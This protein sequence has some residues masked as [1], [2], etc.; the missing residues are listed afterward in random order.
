[1]VMFSD[2][3]NVLYTSVGFSG[4]VTPIQYSSVVQGAGVI[5]TALPPKVHFYG[6]DPSGRLWVLHQ[7]GWDANG[8]PVWAR[9]LPLDRYVARVASPQS[10]LQAATLF[11]AGHDQTLHVLSQDRTSKLWKRSL[12]QRPGQQAVPVDPVPDAADGDRPQRQSRPRGGGHHRRRRGGSDPSRRQNLFRGSRRADRDDQDQRG[13]G[14]DPQ[15]RRDQPGLTQL[16]GYRPG[17]GGGPDRPPRPGLPQLSGTS[18]INTGSAVIRPMSQATLQKATVA[19]QPLSPK[20]G[21]SQAG[22]AANIKNAMESVPGEL[23]GDP[24]RPPRR[25]S[26]MPAIP[27]TPIPVL[28]H[29]GGPPRH[30]A[31]PSRG[32]GSR[33]AGRTARRP[34]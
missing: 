25:W 27:T 31:R 32:R 6:V 15:H 33:P 21:P 8:A 29:A 5:D 22:W 12:V 1:M 10:A 34:R 2:D 13:R 23:R 14:A 20:A 7:T 4:Q 28:Q 9:I 16:H 11:A 18:G 3:Q 19:G 30:H 17:L 26:R 24:G